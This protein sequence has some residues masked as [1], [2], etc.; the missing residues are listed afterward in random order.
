MNLTL[1]GLEIYVSNI[2]EAKLENIS[3]RENLDYGTKADK[4][5]FKID[6]KPLENK[7]I[8]MVIKEVL[9]FNREITALEKEINNLEK[10]R[11]FQKKKF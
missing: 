2:H 11:L 5:Y 10:I 6:L 3:F 4:I 8:T 7:S 1:E 9:E